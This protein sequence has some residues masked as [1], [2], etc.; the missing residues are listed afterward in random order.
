MGRVSKRTSAEE[1]GVVDE[2]W[3]EVKRAEQESRSRVA[4]R[5]SRRL[6]HTQWRGPAGAWPKDEGGRRLWTGRGAHLPG[7]REARRGEMGGSRTRLIFV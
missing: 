4:A 5:L 2:V 6:Y 3:E 1:V 7:T